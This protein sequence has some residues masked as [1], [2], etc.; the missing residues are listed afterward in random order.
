MPV[1][2]WLAAG[3]PV[4]LLVTGCAGT[5]VTPD[6]DRPPAVAVSFFPMADAAGRIAGDAVEVVN[7]TPPGVSPHEVEITPPQRAAVES[8]GALVYLGSGLQPT[9]QRLADAVAGDVRTVDLLAAVELLPVTA[10]APGFDE[11]D[12]E[13][14]AGGTDPHV[15]LSPRRFSTMVGELAG[16]LGELAPSSRAEIE[17]AAAAYRAELAALDQAFDERLAGCDSTALVTGHRAFEYLARD[18]GLTQIPIGGLDPAAEPDP[19]AIQAAA[20]AARAAGATTVFVEEELPPG[21]A[22]TV[23]REIG[24]DTAVLG[25][26]ETITQEEL[27]AGASYVSI[28]RDN[29]DALAAGLRCGG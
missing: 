11:V 19:R 14:L 26:I 17:A 24:A 3:I 23:A 20:A 27:D 1:L 25:S 29:L 28:Q 4:A 10:P 5:P 8:A 18:Y 15:W 9:V 7:L 13:V 2:P 16:V 12:G 21:L 6:P 22:E